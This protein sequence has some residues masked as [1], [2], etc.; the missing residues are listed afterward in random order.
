M[1]SEPGE[2]VLGPT[3]EGLVTR[4]GVANCDLCREGFAPR[5]R[6]SDRVRSTSN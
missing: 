4:L 3:T 5:A 1:G 6:L 2:V